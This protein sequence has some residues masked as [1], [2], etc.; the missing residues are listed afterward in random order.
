MEGRPRESEEASSDVGR[1]QAGVGCGS[2]HGRTAEGGGLEA[3][4]DDEEQGGR[5]KKRGSKRGFRRKRQA[6]VTVWK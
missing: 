4:D 6:I 2:A 3:G 5:E 1:K